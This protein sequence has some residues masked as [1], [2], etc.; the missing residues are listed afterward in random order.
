V[1]LAAGVIGWKRRSRANGRV[2]LAAAVSAL[3]Y[4]ASY[5]PLAPA[6]DLRYLTW[7]IVAAPIAV[8]FALSRA[9]S[10]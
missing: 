2:A 8:A 7:P 4:A 10:R 5:V 6:A 9:R 3:L 1:A